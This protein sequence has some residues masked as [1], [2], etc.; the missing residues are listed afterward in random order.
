M[1]CITQE[2]GEHLLD[3]IHSGSYDNHVASRTLVSKAFRARFYWSSAVADTE[4]LV[5]HYEGCQFFAKRIHVLAH[6]IKTIPA[7]WPFAC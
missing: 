2:E 5:H 6:E 7:S 4:K 1:K 3:Q